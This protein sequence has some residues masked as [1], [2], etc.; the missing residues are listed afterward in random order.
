MTA[1]EWTLSNVA[2]WLFWLWILNWGG[3]RRI[4]GWKSFFLTAWAIRWDAEQLRLYALCMLIVN[5]VWYFV[6]L[7]E[8]GCRV[9]DLRDAR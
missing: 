8:P 2:L 5:I 7:Y 4:E 9:F 1:L 3:A 6:G